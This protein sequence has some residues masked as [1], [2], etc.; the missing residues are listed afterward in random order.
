MYKIEEALSIIGFIL[1]SDYRHKVLAELKKGFKTPKLISKDTG[2][3]INHVSN[4]LKELSDKGLISCKTPELRKGRI[5]Q[6]T[7][8][9][10]DIL[11]RINKI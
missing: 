4:V 11:S 6:I 7:N 9:G 3:Q 5:Y 8:K 10:E 1:G 2:I